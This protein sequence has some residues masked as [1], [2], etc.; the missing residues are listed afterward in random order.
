M[1]E[2]NV[3]GVVS[4]IAATGRP[5]RL[6][7]LPRICETENTRCIPGLPERVRGEKDTRAYAEGLERAS[8]AEGT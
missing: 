2:T 5:I 4:L 3:T 6:L 8:D 1:R 7:Q